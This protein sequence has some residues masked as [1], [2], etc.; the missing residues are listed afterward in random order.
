M[1][2]LL[3]IVAILGAVGA[4]VVLSAAGGNGGVLK[5]YEIE[6][7]NAFGLV[8]GG[9]LRIG[10][11]NVGKTTKFKLTRKQPYKTL[12][13]SEV[14]RPGFDS[15]R[16]DARCDVRQQSLI[17]EYFIDCE[18]G[19]KEQPELP[20]G[21]RVPVER[22][23]SAIGLDLIQNIMRRPYR[24]RFRLILT[25][26]GTALT[27]RSEDLNAVIR[28][29]HPA[30][31][32]TTETL[33]ILRRQNRDM[34]EF[35]RNADTIYQHLRP[36][37]EELARWAREAS[38]TAGIQASRANELGRQ[39]NRF[40]VFLRE[41]RPTMRQ[42]GQTAEAQIPTLRKLTRAAPELEGFLSD[43]QPFARASRRA[44]PALGGASVTGRRAIR[45]SREEITELRRLA[46]LAP[47]LGKPLR[48]LLQTIDDRKRSIENDPEARGTAPPAP[49]K[50]AYSPGRGF[51]PM[52]GI[53]NYIYWQTLAINPADEFGH[54]LRLFGFTGPPCSAYNPNPKAAKTPLGNI[55]SY[56]DN[57]CRSWTGPYQPGV[58]VEDPTAR[59]ASSRSRRG[60]PRAASRPDR[61]ARGAGEPVAPPVRGRRDLSKPQIVLPDIGRQLMDGLRDPTS[62][63]PRPAPGAGD[64]SEQLLDYLLAP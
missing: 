33:A 19:S 35:F 20:D 17:G 24:E 21:G 37:R 43:V 56:T 28:R 46:R 55:N 64:R 23:S 22:T 3:S 15:L 51:T 63:L 39:W 42:L 25:E 6:L 50:T 53:F 26:L 8:E 30:L 27:G 41:L 7:D 5:T 57:G 48:Q 1:R 61:R 49:D 52:E 45:R 9:D 4:A 58:T 13:V 62:K 18:I 47:R 34:A 29:A 38:Q 11:V 12:V 31:R 10:G 32:E 16:K 59:G 2:R 60:Q 44:I 14:T 54:L 36:A 40:P